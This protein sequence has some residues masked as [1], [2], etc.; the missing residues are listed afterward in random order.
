MEKRTTKHYLESESESDFG[1]WLA[2]DLRCIQV[3]NLPR[4]EHY[5]KFK[6]LLPGSSLNFEQ[7]LLDKNPLATESNFTT[8]ELNCQQDSQKCYTS[9]II[10]R[11][12]QR[13]L[14]ENL[15]NVSKPNLKLNTEDWISNCFP[16]K[17]NQKKKIE[18]HQ[19]K[20]NCST[21][22]LFG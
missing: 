3:F 9:K 7:F 2:N 15:L 6:P 17:I 8:S 10:L 14:F 4:G 11:K 19:F 16:I 21:W 20:S 13:T 18:I 1:Q 22:F 5:L 12:C